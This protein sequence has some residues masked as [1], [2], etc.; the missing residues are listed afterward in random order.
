MKQNAKVL[1]MP[2]EGLDNRPPDEEQGVKTI[3]D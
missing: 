2:V 1:R 3:Q